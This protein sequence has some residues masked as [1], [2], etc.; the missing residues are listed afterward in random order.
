MDP[1]SHVP[2]V[3]LFHFLIHAMPLSRDEREHLSECSYC[4]SVVEQFETYI[5]P[6]MIHAA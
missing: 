4:Q 6:E 5:P 3:K 1:T 2:D